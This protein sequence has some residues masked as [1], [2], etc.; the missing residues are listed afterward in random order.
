MLS[1]NS[2]LLVTAVVVLAA[3]LGLTGFAL[4]KAF[5]ESALEAVRERLQIHIYLLLSAAEVGDR[6]TLELPDVL[7]EARLSSPAS[8]LFAEIATDDGQL[9][10][11]S[12]S[13]LSRDIPYPETEKTGETAFQ[14][15]VSKSGES[16][17][18]LTFAVIWVD[19]DEVEKK[20]VFRVSESTDGYLQQVREFRQSLW[21]WFSA[22]AVVLLFLQ[23]LILR[24]GLAPLRRVII[25]LGEIERGNKSGLSEDYPREIRM[26]SANLNAFIRFGQAQLQRYRNA[27]DDLAHSL[28]TPL[29]VLQSANESDSSITALRKT[30]FNEVTR[31]QQVVD[32]QLQRAAASG[33][34]PLG[35]PVPVIKVIARLTDSLSKVY[36]DNNIQYSIAVDP[37][38]MF[39]GDE[40]DLTEI[41]GNLL[42]N[43]SKWAHKK[44]CISAAHSSENSD[45]RHG[46]VLSI[47]DD[48]PGFC[49]RDIERLLRRGARAVSPNAGQGIG[50]T[51]A[52]EIVEDLYH[53]Y[54]SVARSQLGG[55]S[56]VLQFDVERI[57]GSA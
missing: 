18:S 36:A 45:G 54:L 40:G 55:A 5:R 14:E 28:K 11:R 57:L 13:T 32:Y 44:V 56:V 38:V 29:A 1:I 41:L 22:A 31:M 37:N 16:L 23:T 6:G 51:V 49:E 20:Y 50:L 42:D 8:G 27:L 26:L 3:F 53:G 10:W 4:D 15:V 24:W 34:S 46:L 12:P 43:A 17:F 48:G 33:R 2:R 19:D 39:Y 7:P 9:V 30:L 21:I 47:E 52:R 35:S 25:E